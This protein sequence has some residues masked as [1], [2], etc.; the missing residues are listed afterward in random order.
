MRWVI[1]SYRRL[2]FWFSFF[3]TCLHDERDA[4][5]RVWGWIFCCFEFLRGREGILKFFF[6]FGVFRGR[7]RIYIEGT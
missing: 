5:D 3:Q 6:F 7:E 2:F 1:S 4:S